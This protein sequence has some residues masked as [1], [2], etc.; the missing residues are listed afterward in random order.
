MWFCITCACFHNNND[1]DD[2]NND[3]SNGKIFYSLR[4]FFHFCEFYVFI[5]GMQ[6]GKQNKNRT[7]ND[8]KNLMTWKSRNIRHFFF[9]DINSV[10]VPIRFQVILANE[11]FVSNFQL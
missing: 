7:N 6:L 3:Q 5:E 8:N 9:Q 2:N 10:F 11:N 4:D 1:D